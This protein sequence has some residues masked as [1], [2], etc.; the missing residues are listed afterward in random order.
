M[1]DNTVRDLVGWAE[2][3]AHV[4]ECYIKY[5]EE[6]RSIGKGY[7]PT[8]LMGHWPEDIVNGLR[9]TIERME[10]MERKADA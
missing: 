9:K 2:D 4:I 3:A 8:G 7:S 5:A 1:P 6:M 10:P